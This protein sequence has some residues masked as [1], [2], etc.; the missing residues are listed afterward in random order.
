MEKPTWKELLA[1]LMRVRTTQYRDDNDHAEARLETL[2]YVVQ[3]MLERL[4][5]TNEEGK[6]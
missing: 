4:S 1:E 2:E 6:S 5:L 3:T